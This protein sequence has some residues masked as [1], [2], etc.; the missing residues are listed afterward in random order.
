MKPYI[1][2]IA[3]SI[4]LT[5]LPYLDSLGQI[6]GYNLFE[7]QL[8]NVPDQKPNDLST[9]YDQLFLSYKHKKILASVKI[10]NFVTP[11]SDKEYLSLSQYNIRYRLKNYEFKVGS[12]YDIIG[13]GL[14]LRAYEIKGSIFE[15]PGFRI[16]QG[17]YNDIKGF[18]A[19][20]SGKVSSIKIIRGRPLLNI[21][22]PTFEEKDR[23]PDLIEALETELSY[24]NQNFGFAVMRNFNQDDEN[25]YISIKQEGNLPFNISYYTEWAQLIGKNQSF[26]STKLN[27]VYAYYLNIN[28]AKGSFGSSIELKAYQNFLLGSG[29]NFPPALV[30]EHAYKTLNRSIHTP[31]LK[32]ERGFQSEFFYSFDNFSMITFNLTNLKNDLSQTYN[33]TELFLEYYLPVDKNSFKLFIDYSQDE[34]VSETDRYAGGIYFTRELEN[35]WSASFEFEYQTLTRRGDNINNIVFSASTSKSNKF[36]GNVVVEV[37]ND[38]V[39]S[40]KGSTFEVEYG[41]TY[42]LGTNINYKYMSHTFNLFAGKRR[43]GPACASGI[44]YEILDFNGIELRIL[45]KF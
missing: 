13:R 8:G 3:F 9:S 18:S 33:F 2:H 36:S 43:G 17:F 15:D 27:D 6:T 30:K 44:C 45:S 38:P 39:F 21:I 32:D 42:W 23:R 41:T 11:E 34:I 28:Y 25:N 22:P 4:I 40:D 29:F 16:R 5:Y 1:Y 10:E 19:K 37:S 35:S 26:G 12:I 24:L 7:Y 20:Y 31:Q 14:L